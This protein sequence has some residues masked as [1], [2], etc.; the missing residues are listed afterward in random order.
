[1]Y[2]S[3]TETIEYKKFLAELKQGVVSLAAMSNKHG[4]ANLRFGVAPDGII[5]E[6]CHRNWRDSN[7]IQIA[8]FNKT[9]LESV[10]KASS[11]IV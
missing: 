4:E 3:E 6:S 5:N 8:I 9:A 10:A 1:M 7:H 11:M 2:T